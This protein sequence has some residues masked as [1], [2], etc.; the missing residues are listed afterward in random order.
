MIA[1]ADV[2]EALR[3][4]PDIDD[5]ALAGYGPG[6]ELPCAVLVRRHLGWND[7]EIIEALAMACQL[8]LAAISAACFR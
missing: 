4:H 8:P 5:A 7:A 1:A 3:G 2:E 6:H